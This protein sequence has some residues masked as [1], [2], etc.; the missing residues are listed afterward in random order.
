MGRDRRAAITKL[1]PDEQM[2]LFREALTAWRD[3]AKIERL[4]DVLM[5]RLVEIDAAAVEAAASNPANRLL[6]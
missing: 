1:E 6:L 3:K 4:R 2:D 5:A